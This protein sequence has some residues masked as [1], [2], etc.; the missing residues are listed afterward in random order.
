MN[1]DKGQN[2]F[3]DNIFFPKFYD[4]SNPKLF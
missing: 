3:N 4:I 2:E 1:H